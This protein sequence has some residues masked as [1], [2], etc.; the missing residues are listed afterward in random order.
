[1][2]Q[3]SSVQPDT[4]SVWSP[5]R[6]AWIVIQCLAILL[7]VL[8]NILLIG[9]NSSTDTAPHEITELFLM[10]WGFMAFFLFA[11]MGLQLKL[12][13]VPRLMWAV[14]FAALAIS[15][16]ALTLNLLVWTVILTSV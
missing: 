1:M 3:S 2:T 16:L 9:P 11:S 5:G 14:S 4:R 8:I 6:R 13:H 15:L 10:T 7:H 12:Q